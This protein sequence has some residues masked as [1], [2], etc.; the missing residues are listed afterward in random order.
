MPPSQ[1]ARIRRATRDRLGV[2]LLRLEPA[3]EQPQPAQ[4]P[5]Q[6]SAQR[7]QQ[8]DRPAGPGVAAGRRARSAGGGGWERARCGGCGLPC[9]RGR[10]AG[11]GGRRERGRWRV[12]HPSAW[13]AAGWAWAGRAR[14]RSEAALARVPA[15]GDEDD[16][17]R[18]VDGQFRFGHAAARVVRRMPS[19][20]SS[21]RGPG[22]RRCR[23]PQSAPACRRARGCRCGRGSARCARG[24]QGGR[25]P[26]ARRGEP[27]SSAI[28][29]AG[30]GDNWVFR[31]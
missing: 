10:R 8:V 28:C 4:R 25:R 18:P 1:A 14:S 13:A 11:R 2:S 17:P 15:A 16:L 26:M 31:S 29:C 7:G 23:A 30:S 21:C 3:I 22:P 19:S 12:S 6:R 9:R 20:R 24:R 5:E 27:G